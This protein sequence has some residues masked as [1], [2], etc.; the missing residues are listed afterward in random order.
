MRSAAAAAAL[1]PAWRAPAPPRRTRPLACTPSPRPRWPRCGARRWIRELPVGSQAHVGAYVDGHDTKRHVMARCGAVPFASEVTWRWWESWVL[2][3][4]YAVGLDYSPLVGRQQ[5][6]APRP[7]LP[8]AL[9]SLR[10][11]RNP[12]P[13]W[14]MPLLEPPAGSDG[15]PGGQ[16]EC[17]RDSEDWPH[18]ALRQ[19]FR[20]RIG[21]SD[22]GAHVARPGE[23]GREGA[24]MGSRRCAALRCPTRAP[25]RP[26][27]A[28]ACR[29]RRALRRQQRATQEGG[30]PH[31]RLCALV[32]A[33][34]PQPARARPPADAHD[35]PRH[36]RPGGPGAAAVGAHPARRQPRR[37]RGGGR[38]GGGRRPAGG[39]RAHGQHRQHHGA[40]GLVRRWR[41][42][43]AQCRCGRGGARCITPACLF[44][45]GAGLPAV[46]APRARGSAGWRLAGCGCLPPHLSA[47]PPAPPARP[48]AQSARRLGG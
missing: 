39:H 14:M 19:E 7:P 27:P 15:S 11:V 31:P 1:V 46:V 33:G 38:G 32:G 43:S 35:G 9:P 20:Q 4:S 44:G 34:P 22:A 24:H 10:A 41:C 40:D 5:S 16:P 23:A 13:A 12:L 2:E 45:A 18:A 28:A 30:A 8:A 47:H 42:A 48:A 36:T 26:P 3:R 25:C 29:P 37:R 17:S 21:A 6:T